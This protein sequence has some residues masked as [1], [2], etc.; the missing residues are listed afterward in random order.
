[1]ESSEMLVKLKRKDIGQLRN[2]KDGGKFGCAFRYIKGQL[3]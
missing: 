2:K 1:M 3:G